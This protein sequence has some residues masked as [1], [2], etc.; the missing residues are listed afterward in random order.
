MYFI[1]YLGGGVIASRL[2]QIKSKL[3]PFYL[4]VLGSS[5]RRTSDGHLCQLPCGHIMLP[6]TSATVTVG[7]RQLVQACTASSAICALLWPD[8]HICPARGRLRNHICA[9]SQYLHT[10]LYVSTC[11]SQNRIIE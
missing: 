1:I 10:S 4:L 5:Q 2:R 9:D 8:V 6:V 3:L 7:R 11:L